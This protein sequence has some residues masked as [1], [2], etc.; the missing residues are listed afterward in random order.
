MRY[1][2]I[3][4]NLD[5]LIRSISNLEEATKP[6]YENFEA[7]YEKSRFGGY[8]AV[9]FNDKEGVSWMSQDSWKNSDDAKKA[10]EWYLGNLKQGVSDPMEHGKNKPKGDYS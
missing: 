3:D 9:V 8:R 2:K 1:G 4:E 7:G 6:D 5:N 10:A